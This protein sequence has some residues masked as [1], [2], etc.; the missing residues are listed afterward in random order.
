MKKLL[1]L[2][3]AFAFFTACN[4][5]KGKTNPDN[6]STNNR[7]KDDYRDNNKDNSDNKDK[8]NYDNTNNDDRNNDRNNDNNDPNP[9]NNSS[10]WTKSDETKFIEL[11]AGTAA[12]N[13]G[14]TRANEY[15]EC[16]LAKVKRIYSSYAEADR[17]LA[18]FTK[19]QIDD[20]AADC[21]R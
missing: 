4:N 11:C 18:D 21:N 2:L 5:N 9:D 16:M 10:G 15:C 17:K 12:Q 20:L 14:A 8:D 6:K 13:V 1:I 3:M 7:D 19:E